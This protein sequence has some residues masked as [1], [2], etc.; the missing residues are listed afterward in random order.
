LVNHKLASAQMHI[1]ENI[2]NSRDESNFYAADFVILYTYIPI[3][4]DSKN[5]CCWNCQ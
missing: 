1:L 3:T 5:R 4:T 2:V